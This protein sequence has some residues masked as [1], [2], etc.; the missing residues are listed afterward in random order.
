[1]CILAFVVGAIMTSDVS[2]LW[3]TK[4]DTKA[5]TTA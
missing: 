1:M 4:E 2:A 5:A 3:Q